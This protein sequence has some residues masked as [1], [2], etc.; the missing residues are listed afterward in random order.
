MM[1]YYYI[2]FIWKARVVFIWTKVPTTIPFWF[3]SSSGFVT[4]LVVF[5]WGI[6][7]LPAG[8]HNTHLL[9]RCVLSWHDMEDP[10]GYLDSNGHVSG[11]ESEWAMRGGSAS[12]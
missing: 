4:T 5:M 2:C 7:G 8:V 3:S 12:G 11:G 6:R 10:R 1:Q 9:A